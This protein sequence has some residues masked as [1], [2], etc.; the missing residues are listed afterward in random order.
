MEAKSESTRKR[1]FSKTND[2]K[3]VVMVT[4]YYLPSHGGIENHIHGLSTALLN[5]GWNVDILSAISVPVNDYIKNRLKVSYVQT[6]W[7]PLNNPI[8]LGMF[9]K[10]LKTEADIIHAHGLYQLSSLIAKIAAS[11][12]QKPVVV[13]VHGLANYSGIMHP[14]QRLY[15]SAFINGPPSVNHFI[16]ASPADQD[17]LLSW[18]V[19]RNKISI[20][21][22]AIDIGYWR[23]NSFSNSERR[24]PDI[25]FVGSLI[26][27]KRPDLLVDAF[28]DYLK[29]EPRACLHIV[30]EG[31]EKEHIQRIIQN[32]G[33]EESV[34]LLGRISIED[35]RSLYQNSMILVLPSIAEGIPTVL[36]EAMACG[37]I[38][39]SSDLAGIRH[40]IEQRKNGFMFSTNSQ[41]SLLKTLQHVHSLS[42]DQKEAIRTNGIVTVQKGYSWVHIANKMQSLYMKLL[43]S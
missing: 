4:S 15:E 9:R 31:P 32:Y 23:T 25:V 21:P 11:L 24:N 19:E 3:S 36:L 28:N 13:S 10:V 34:R 6:I 27:R 12:R 30:G 17:F 7:N 33:I 43:D 42:P 26:Y 35:L 22:N 18:G 41:A 2:N 29:D 38:V 39:V 20:I 37:M 1:S 14:I 40:V 5:R 16:A 8:A